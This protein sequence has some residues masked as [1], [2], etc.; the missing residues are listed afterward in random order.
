MHRSEKTTVQVDKKIK[1]LFKLYCAKKGY[2]ISGKVEQLML[3]C[4]S[5]SI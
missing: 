3:M 5:G 2:K 4:V 1:D